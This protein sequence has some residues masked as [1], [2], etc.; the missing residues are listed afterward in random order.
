MLEHGTLSS[1]SMPQQPNLA[2]ASPTGDLCS[3]MVSHLSV[4]HYE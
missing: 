4:Y 3:T 2:L 1:L